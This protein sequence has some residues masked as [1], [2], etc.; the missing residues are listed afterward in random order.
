M[1]DKI[2]LIS[3]MTNLDIVVY[4]ANQDTFVTHPYDLG[5]ILLMQQVPC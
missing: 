1:Y 5:L 2:Y 4:N 3:T